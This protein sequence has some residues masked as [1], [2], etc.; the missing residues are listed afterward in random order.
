MDDTYK[1][2]AKN[3][4]NSE[5]IRHRNY[6]VRHPFQFRRVLYTSCNW[7]VDWAMNKTEIETKQRTIILEN[8]RSCYLYIER[9]VRSGNDKK[10]E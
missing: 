8:V 10:K 7:T 3:C 4:S 2:L 9:D 6:F 5:L 1:F